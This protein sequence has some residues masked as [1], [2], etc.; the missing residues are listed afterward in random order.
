MGNPAKVDEGKVEELL[1]RAQREIDG[2]LLPSCQVALAIDGVVVVNEA[3]GDSTTDTR[4]VIFS[5]TKPSVAAA[6]WLLI[7]SGD[8][9]VSRT[10]ASYIP[11]FGENGK[12]AIT[13]EQVMLHTSGFPRAPLGAPVWFTREG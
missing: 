9:D 2:G 13:V 3:Y 5:A 7:D 12:D 8:L 6:C 4:Y 1:K 11:E 10:V